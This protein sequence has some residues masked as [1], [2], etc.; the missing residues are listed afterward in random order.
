MKINIHYFFIMLLAGIFLTACKTNKFR[1]SS[2]VWTV[3][4]ENDI[5]VLGARGYGNKE[6]EAI[7]DAEKRAFE[8]LFYRGLPNSSY[9]LPMISDSDRNASAISNFFNSATYRNFITGSTVITPLSK[10]KVKKTNELDIELSINS[11]ALRRHLENIGIIKKF[12]L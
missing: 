11:F 2:E 7:L 10:N 12:G 4:Q 6:G 9:K 5:L 3:R 1:T 8:T